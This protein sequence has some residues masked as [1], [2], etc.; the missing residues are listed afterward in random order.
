MFENYTVE[1]PFVLPTADPQNDALGKVADSSREAR[2]RLPIRAENMHVFSDGDT[3]DITQSS[4]APP[5]DQPKQLA[6]SVPMVSTSKRPI[7]GPLE[8]NNSFRYV[9]IYSGL[10]RVRFKLATPA[11][12][13]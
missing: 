11:L 6:G 2:S 7:D 1:Q 13:N 12:I 10:E 5:I 9:C 8:P 4:P 3:L